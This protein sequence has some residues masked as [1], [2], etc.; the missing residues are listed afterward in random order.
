MKAMLPIYIALIT[1]SFMTF[2]DVTEIDKPVVK[3]ALIELGYG[4]LVGE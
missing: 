4:H 1:R 3:T 2:D